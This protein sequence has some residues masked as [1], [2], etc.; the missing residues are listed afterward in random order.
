MPH[1]LNTREAGRIVVA[2]PGAD[3]A[4]L[5]AGTVQCVHCGGHF[6]RR[7]GSGTVRGFCMNCNGFVCGPGCEACVPTEQLLENIEAGRPLAF[8]PILAS[9]PRSL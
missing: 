1:T 3:K 7:P 9:V 8:R 4:L 5:E 6:V 2:D